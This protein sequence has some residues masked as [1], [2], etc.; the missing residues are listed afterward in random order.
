MLSPF[1]LGTGPKDVG[2][3]LSFIGVPGGYSL[4]KNHFGIANKSMKK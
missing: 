1:Y 2:D 3:M 4:E